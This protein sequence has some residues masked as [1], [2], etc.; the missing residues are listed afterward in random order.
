[1]TIMALDI[2]KVRTGVAISDPSDRIAHPVTVLPSL[3]LRAGSSAFC[4]LLSDYQVKSLL[5]GLPL[6]LDGVEH[7]QAS[8]VRDVA[9]ELGSR[10][11]MPVSFHDER[12]TSRQA[13]EMMRGSGLSERQMRGRL[14]MV[15]ASLILQDYLDGQ[16]TS[17]RGHQ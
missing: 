3:E 16:G 14:D 9:N 2:G 11:E 15:A 5:V 1:M 10:Y 17:E 12:L 7:G 8:W 6:S 4:R 13:R